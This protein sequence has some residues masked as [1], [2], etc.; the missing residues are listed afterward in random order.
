MTIVLPKKVEQHLPQRILVTDAGGCIGAQA[1]KLLLA[2]GYR[3]VAAERPGVE[4]PEGPPAQMEIRLGNLA[5][6]EYAT[7]LASGVDAILHIAA[8]S[9]NRRPDGEIAQ[10]NHAATIALYNAARV[11]GTQKFIYFSSGLLYLIKTR[12]AHETDHLAAVSSCGFSRILAEEFLLSR[13][14]DGPA[15][16]VLRT[17]LV[18]G[19]CRATFSSLLAIVPELLRKFPRYVPQLTGGPRVNPVHATDAARAAIHLLETDQPHG[20]IFNIAGAE[21]IAS[22]DIITYVL[23]ETGLRVLPMPIPVTMLDWIM[24]M[25]SCAEIIAVADR[26]VGSIWWAVKRCCRTDRQR[27]SPIDPELAE[28]LSTG[29]VLDVSKLLGTGFQFNHERVAPAWRDIYH[30]FEQQ[31]WLLR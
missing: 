28:I 16:N 3:V 26:A 12:A 31:G 25:V 29:L 13:Q 11:A 2:K 14:G 4:I 7:G 27:Y 23:V 5:D 22:S 10:V 24:P 15:V 6:A 9:D 17:G 20:E 21:T 19:P 1:V 30:W 18:Y 8:I